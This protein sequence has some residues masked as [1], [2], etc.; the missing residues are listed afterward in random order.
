MALIKNLLGRDCDI[1]R[2]AIMPVDLHSWLLTGFLHEAGG[3]VSQLI[4]SSAH[5][6]NA[7]IDEQPDG[8]L[9][10]PFAGHTEVDFGPTDLHDGLSV[11]DES[12]IQDSL[13]S[14]SRVKRKSKPGLKRGHW[15]TYEEED[16][17]SLAGRET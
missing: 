13:L 12:F 14:S 6:V 8:V 3:Y 7:A 4:T 15:E 10:N 2:L 17:K 11:E 1:E 5:F 9:S 16:L